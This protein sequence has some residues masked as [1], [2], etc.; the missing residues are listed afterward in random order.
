LIFR[1]PAG[2]SDNYRES[3]KVKDVWGP[4][5]LKLQ[6]AVR[7]RELHGWDDIQEATMLGLSLVSQTG[8]KDAETGLQAI[9]ECPVKTMNISPERR[10]FQVDTGPLCFP[11]L[12]KRYDPQIDCLSLAFVAF[13]SE[14]SADFIVE[15]PTGVVRGG[16]EICSIY[17]YSNPFSLE[18]HNVIYS[19][20]SE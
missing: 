18:A 10:M 6:E 5:V 1:R 13:N 14:S 11:D 17:H 15:Q 9:I 16:T 20:G 19:L 12:S 3:T 4:P 8:I 7:V 2:L